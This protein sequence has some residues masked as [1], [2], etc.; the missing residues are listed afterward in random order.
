MTQPLFY[1]HF[2]KVALLTLVTGIMLVAVSLFMG[3]NNFFLLLNTDLGKVADVFFHYW[4]YAGDGMICVP[5]ALYFIIYK[6]RL[7]PLL[8]STILLTTLLTQGTKNFIFPGEPRPT[9]A[10]TDHSLI[11]TVEGVELHTINS[12]PSGHTATAFSVLLVACLLWRSKWLF[13][14]G[15][16][17][18]LLV[19]YSR[20]YLAQHFPLDVGAGMLAAVISVYLALKIQERFSG[21][22]KAAV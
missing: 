4:T 7:L 3:K 2:R 5:V 10:L 6:R 17:A 12:F 14:V 15:F 21:N 20:I 8:L 13:P 22:K 18:A 9:Q 19:G 16:T 11:H 1:N